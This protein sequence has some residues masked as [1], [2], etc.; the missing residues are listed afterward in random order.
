[1]L[2]AIDSSVNWEETDL[3]LRAAAVQLTATPDKARNLQTADRLV[4]R[5]AADGARLVVLPE[6]WSVLG[7]GDDL[8]AGAEPLDG[9][10][11]TW[12]RDAAREL[13]IDLVAGS[14]SERVDGERKLRNT[15]LHIG[16][17]GEV[18]AV[19]RKVHM[20]DVEVDGTVYRESEHE[21]PGDDVVL[22]ETADGTT[23]G[24]TVCYDVRFPE[25]YRILAI[26][27]A[28]IITIPAAFTVPTTRDHWE[29]LVRARAIEDQCFVIAANQVGEHVEGLRSGGRSMIVDPWGLV[30]AQA[31]DS[32]TVITADL[33]LDAQDAIRTR[34]P[35][36]AN[37]RPTAYRW[38]EL[39]EAHS[40]S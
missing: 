20:F 22:S 1:M 31:A 19:Y 5:A 14:V 15:S 2:S 29:V 35:S 39:A 24:L 30:L 6:K 25:L 36:L 9:A 4:R 18:K 12:A 3:M 21:A 33:D 23:L 32:E 10:A 28:R 34:L 11:V 40:A 8:R 13:G 37:R 17:D 16:P 27:G 7:R 26:R 38:P